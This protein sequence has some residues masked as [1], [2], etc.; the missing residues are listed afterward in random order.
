[1]HH[2]CD[3]CCHQDRKTQR[4]LVSCSQHAPCARRAAA[5]RLSLE[6]TLAS[7]ERCGALCWILSIHLGLFFAQCAALGGSVIPK[8]FVELALDVGRNKRVT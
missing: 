1:M 4:A 2:S 7:G 3:L 6:A 8:A 5:A